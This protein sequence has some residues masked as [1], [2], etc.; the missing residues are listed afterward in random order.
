MVS[1]AIKWDDDVYLIVLFIV[2]ANAKKKKVAFRG[3]AQHTS[4]V[5]FLYMHICIFSLL[6]CV[7]KTICHFI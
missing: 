3:K 4:K 2:R 7:M 6:T 1:T 5:V